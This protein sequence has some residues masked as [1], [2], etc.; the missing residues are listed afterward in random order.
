MLKKISNTNMAKHPK[1][2]KKEIANWGIT[3]LCALIGAVLMVGM[4]FGAA[5]QEQTKLVGM[6]ACEVSE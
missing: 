6:A 1:R 2:I 5:I 3:I 4:I